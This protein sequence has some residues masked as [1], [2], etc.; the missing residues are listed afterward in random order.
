MNLE[1]LEITLFPVNVESFETFKPN[2]LNVI[3]LNLLSPE[4]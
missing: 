1:M 3:F 2:C 4:V